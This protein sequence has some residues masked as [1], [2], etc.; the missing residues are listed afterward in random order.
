MKSPSRRTFSNGGG[1]ITLLTGSPHITIRRVILTGLESPLEVHTMK[2]SASLLPVLGVQ[3]AMGR[4]FTSKEDLKGFEHVAILTD[5]L[6]RMRFAADPK[7]AGRPITM[8]GEAYT[9]VGVLPRGFVFPGNEVVDLLTPLGKDEAAELAFADGKLTAIRNVIGRLKPGVTREQADADLMSIVDR[10]PHPPWTMRI[11]IQMLG[12][13]DRLYGNAKTAGW[14]LLAAAG[15]LLWIACANVSNLLLAR[16]TQRD[17]ELSIRAVLGGS[18]ARLI[19]QL[20]TESALLSFIACGLGL[21]LA[22]WLRRPIL[23]FSPYQLAGLDDLPFDGRVLGFAIVCGIATVIL[24]GVL[25]AFRATEIRLA[26]SVKAGEA[27]VIGG[28]GS[29]RILSIIAALEIATLLMLSTSAGVMLKS[30]WKM[31]YQNLGFAPD[32]LI[33]ATLTL[34]GARSPKQFGFLDR[35]L[36]RAQNLPGVEAAAITNSGE[37]P[38]GTWHAT[39]VFLVEARAADPRPGHRPIARFQPASSGIFSIL[40]IPLLKGRLFALADRQ[41]VVIV[42]RALIEKYFRDENAIGQHVR[43]GPNTAPWFEII[44][45]VADV[46][47][48]GLA[49]APEPAVYYPYW[50]GDGLTYVGLILRSPLNAGVMASEIRKAVV[51]IDPNQPVATVESLDDR[52]TKS[53]STPRFTAALLCAFAGLA[54]VLGIIGVYGVVSCRVR[55]QM[56]ELAVRQALGAQAGDVIRH[57]LRQGLGMIAVGIAAGLAGSLALSRMLSGMLYEVRANDPLTLIG[58][59]LALSVIALAACWIPARRAARVDPLVLLRYE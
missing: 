31:R 24:F 58:V 52:L 20:M 11:T 50:Q 49:A 3:P 40:Q 33:A 32:H 34:P 9:I 54:A 42:N 26:E 23:A 5:W 21:A 59:A 56:R 14:I 17:R 51:N 46:K 36:E 8:D 30:F 6:W 37:I 16:L 12:L 1:R 41:P 57:V 13:R 15:F 7:I 25:P 4:N 43:F 38:P 44:G 19:A 35:L 10:L 2:A 27:A 28:R 39:N 53:V 47:T 48:S 55:W 18:R 22:W 29:L 45:I